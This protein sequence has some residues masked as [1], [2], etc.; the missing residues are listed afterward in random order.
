MKSIKNVFPNNFKENN[1]KEEKTVFLNAIKL[2]DG[3]STIIR[4]F[5][6]KYIESIDYPHNA[7]S[8]LDEYDEVKESEQKSEEGIRE[9]VKFRRQEKSDENNI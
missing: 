5:G 9:R 2:Y 7:K 8:E 1:L 3:K 6:N 4:L